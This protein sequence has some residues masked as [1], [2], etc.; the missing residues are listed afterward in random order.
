VSL[1]PLA[2]DQRIELVGRGHADKEPVALARRLAPEV[3]VMDIGIPGLDGIEATRR[4]AR[5]QSRPRESFLIVEAG[6]GGESEQDSCLAGC[7]RQTP[8]SPVPPRYDEGTVED[9]RP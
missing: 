4:I 9:S 7:H 1:I 2:S 5:T 6:L 3:I 8:G